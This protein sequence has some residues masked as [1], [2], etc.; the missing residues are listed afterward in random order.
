MYP[1]AYSLL[2]SLALLKA[3]FAQTPPNPTVQ[4][5]TDE[6]TCTVSGTVFR[7]ADGVPLK[8]AL[9]QLLMDNDR[10]HAIATRSTL[11]GKFLLQNL[12]CEKYSMMVSRNG[13]V[14]SKYGQK[15]PSDPGTRFSLRPGQKMEGLVFYLDRAAVITGRVFD[16]DGEPMP[17]VTVTTLRQGF[18]QGRKRLWP[19]AVATTNDL[20]E[21]RVY[22][23]QAGRY[24]LKAE[25]HTWG[26][27]VGEKQYSGSEKS[28]PERAYKGLCYPGTTDLSKASTVQVR[29]A[30]EAPSIDFLMKEVPVVRL[31]GRIVSVLPKI[32]NRNY[33]DVQVNPRNQ[34]EASFGWSYSSE[35]VRSDGSFEV[36]DVIPGEYT[37]TATQFGED[38][39]SATQMDLDV[40]STDINDLLLVIGGGF[41]V[42][43][44]V[45]WEGKPS[46]EKDG[47]AVSAVPP[48]F[49]FYQGQG[50][51]SSVDKNSQ[52]VWK[53]MPE[54]QYQVDIFGMG[55]DVYVKEIKA[56][57]NRAEGNVIKLNKGT[58]EVQITLSSRGARLQGMVI[59][60]EN[61]PAPGV[62]TVAIAENA[63]IGKRAWAATTDQNG[64]YELRGLPPGKYKLYSWQDIEES[65]WDDPDVV[66]PYE[67]KGTPIE[68]QDG[69]SKTADQTLINLKE[70][71]PKGE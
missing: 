50:G 9:V 26:R 47:L 65:S 54:G 66:K 24:Y 63:W 6:E 18:L 71:A 1:R 17:G 59:T 25:P 41:E 11:D 21:Y 32:G 48:G 39:N 58:A 36:P 52:F 7:K 4:P 46:V 56:G 30:E 3:A 20:G 69:D 34:L 43:G 62:W 8:N 45:I 40:G 53:D 61:L 13:Y 31:R 38:R 60:E 27:V 35:R 14:T 29:E 64:H 55:K 16:E 28:A 49:D 2:L 67:D 44:T 19:A 10:D 22:G 12:P 70:A 15:K 57:E 37:I 51:H 5:K 33:F 68:L 23:L 42:H